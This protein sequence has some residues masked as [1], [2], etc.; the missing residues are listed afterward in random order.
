MSAGVMNGDGE[1]SWRGLQVTPAH[2]TL[3]LQVVAVLRCN[4]RS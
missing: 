1:I 2:V 4:V 3:G